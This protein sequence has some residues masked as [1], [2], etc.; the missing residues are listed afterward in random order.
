MQRRFHISYHT[1]FDSALAAKN[2]LQKQRPNE[3]FQIRKRKSNYD[4]VG[5]VTVSEAVKNNEV[6]H[7]IT[8]KKR[9]PKR[10]WKKSANAPE[11]NLEYNNEKA[12]ENN[13][14]KWTDRKG[15]QI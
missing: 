13:T 6:I 11:F 10:A 7:Q 4:L 5:R 1:D 15:V 14:G 9:K 8:P 3:Y 2:D 12:R